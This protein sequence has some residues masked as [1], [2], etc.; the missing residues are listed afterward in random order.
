ME[1]PNVGLREPTL[2][3]VNLPPLSLY[4]PTCKSCKSELPSSGEHSS[5]GHLEVAGSLEGYLGGD[6]E[7][8]WIL[9]P[10]EAGATEGGF[11]QYL[12]KVLNKCKPQKAWWGVAGEV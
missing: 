12:K 9:G 2:N 6:L 3:P 10:S 7:L 11:Q 1:T 4:S 8:G 5:G